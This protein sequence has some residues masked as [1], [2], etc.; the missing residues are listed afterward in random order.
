MKK[1]TLCLALLATLGLAGCQN[2]V[3]L[4]TTQSQTQ[5]NEQNQA[6][7]T[8]AAQFIEDLWA[9]YPEASSWAGYGKYDDIITIPD[10]ASRVSSAAFVAKQLA[11]LRQFDLTKLTNANKIDYH[12]LENTLL[13]SEWEANTFKSYQ[14]DP[15]SY[16]VAYGFASILN[17]RF[18]SDD[19]K[20]KLILNR[21]QYVPAYYS[22]A[23]ANITIPTLEFTQLGIAQ[24]QGAFSVLND[25]LLAK[26][27]DS[28][29]TAAEQ[30]LFTTR[31]NQAK[32]AITDYIEFLTQLEQELTANG[33]ARSFR[34]GEE[35]YEAKFAFDIQSGYS[36]KQMFAKAVAD[37]TRVTE[38]MAKLTIQLWPKYF[39]NVPMPAKERDAVAMLIK[40]LS[41]KHVAREDFVS[42]I[43]A[44]IPALEQFVMDKGL[45]GL[46]A[47]KPLVVRETP[48]YMRGF[49]GASISAPGPYEKKENTYYNVSPLDDM[50][51][52]QAESYLR[53][54]NHW[55]LQVLNIHEAVPGHYTQLVYSNESPSLVKSIFANGAMVEGWAVYTERMMLEEGYGDFEPEMWLMYYKW[56]LRVICN[57]ILDYSIHVNNMSKEDG[58]AL[59]MD[60]AF[61]E[62]TEAEG[63]WRRATLSQVQLTSY[64]SGYREIYDFREAQKLKLGDQFKLRAFHD[65][66]LSFGSAPVKYIKELMQY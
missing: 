21:L 1:T 66:F 61:Q 60:E 34:I 58:I 47:N 26:L 4:A 12:L 41:A 11:K 62:R 13:Q 50:S 57:T 8:F 52:E 18:K 53:E 5:V 55:I 46:D 49:A 15:S 23:E 33:N 10:E 37:K 22:A 14:W 2:S 6:F 38:E 31:F 43:K 44:Q 27:A 17:S 29:L 24:N 30:T 63:K 16:N 59:L 9:Q 40:H 39:P 64:Y 32:Q 36:A 51:D 28:K 65:E 25:E 19:E 42:E 54:Y 20:L 7:Q 45:I 48:E 35:L 56:N 3:T